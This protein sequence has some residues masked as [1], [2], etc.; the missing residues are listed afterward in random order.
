LEEENYLR[1]ACYCHLMQLDLD[2]VFLFLL[3]TFFILFDLERFG[4]NN[5]GGN[6]ASGILGG[7]QVVH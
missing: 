4:W 2:F 3:F 1:I 7:E 6:Q 5:G